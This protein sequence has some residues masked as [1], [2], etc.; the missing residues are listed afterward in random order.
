MTGDCVTTFA[1]VWIE[2]SCLSDPT[3]EAG[4]TTFAVVWIEMMYRTAR[5]S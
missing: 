4:V 5:A 1:V 3:I 2:I